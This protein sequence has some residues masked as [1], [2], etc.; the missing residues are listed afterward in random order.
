[1]NQAQ[2]A[3][4]LP[5]CFGK[6][7]FVGGLLALLCFGPVSGAEGKT[8]IIGA[9]AGNIR[10]GPSVQS[11]V[12]TVLEQGVAVELLEQQGRWIRIRLDDG[13]EGWAHQVVFSR[14][15]KE[16]EAY[17]LLHI[18]VEVLE[19]GAERARFLL[20]EPRPPKTFTLE[21]GN[22]RLVCDFSGAV[23]GEGVEALIPSDGKWIRRIRVG[24]H[25]GT[26]GKVRAVL[27]L[28]AGPDYEVRQMILEKESLY[29]LIVQ[30]KE[31]EKSEK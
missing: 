25:A 28:T 8:L 13:R 12:L 11:E 17:V 2:R 18:E 14:R 15:K 20:S 24:Y 9:K 30:E 7:L 5:D 29:F 21:D 6:Y 27:D 16:P 1:M 26:P 10:K 4:S 22:P 3:L 31:K 23:L 19:S